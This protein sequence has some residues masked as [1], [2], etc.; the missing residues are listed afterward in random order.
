MEVRLK[1]GDKVEIRKDLKD[2][3]VYGEE[4]F[5]EDMEVNCGRWATIISIED[6]TNNLYEIDIDNFGWTWSIDMFT[7]E[8]VIKN[9]IGREV[10][11]EGEIALK[12]GIIVGMDLDIHNKN[13]FLVRL[14]EQTSGVGCTFDSAIEMRDEWY[15][16]EYE[17]RAIWQYK[18]N[19]YGLD[20]LSSAP[21]TV[22]YEEIPPIVEE[23]FEKIKEAIEEE[24]EEKINYNGEY[25]VSFNGCVY[26]GR[27]KVY[28]DENKYLKMTLSNN[29][30][31]V[32]QGKDAWQRLQH[33]IPVEI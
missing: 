4:T 11:V 32:I 7:P 21:I 31:L 26:Y 15:A 17:G 30:L 28:D 33:I 25:A 8:S 2:S 29:A 23:G 10:Y 9:F 3:V 24:I 16:E 19:V 27:I 22:D 18:D 6:E 20:E 5:I 13:P 14:D 12:R 1:V